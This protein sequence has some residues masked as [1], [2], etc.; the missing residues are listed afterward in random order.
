MSN[1]N[2]YYSEIFHDSVHVATLVRPKESPEGLSFITDDE[3]FLQ[4]GIWNYKKNQDL[5]LHFHNEFER[6]SYKTNEFVFVLKGEIEC[7]L[8][9]EEGEF[10]ES[11]IVKES[12][13]IIQHNHAHE[14]KILKDSIILESKNGPFL[15]VERDKTFIYAKKKEN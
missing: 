4:L 5:D 9:T 6:K 11:I 3:K 1:T 15:G 12:E 14:Y 13:G 8:Y 10:I 2:S 7:N